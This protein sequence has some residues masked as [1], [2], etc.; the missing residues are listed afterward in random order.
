MVSVSETS[1]FFVLFPKKRSIGTK[2]N[3]SYYIIYVR[4]GS[5][6]NLTKTVVKCNIVKTVLTEITDSSHA[7]YKFGIIG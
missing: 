3:S 6:D 7:R 1:S 4:P 5:L 2:F